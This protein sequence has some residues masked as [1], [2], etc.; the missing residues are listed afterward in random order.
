MKVIASLL[1]SAVAVAAFG[2]TDEPQPNM[3]M[4]KGP[5][6]G[7]MAQP[8]TMTAQQSSPEVK[9]G[10]GGSAICP[11]GSTWGNPGNYCLDGR[12][13]YYCSYP[14]APGQMSQNCGSNG[15][16]VAPPG[17]PDGCNRAPPPTYNPPTYSPPTPSP[18]PSMCY[19]RP[20]WYGGNACEQFGDYKGKDLAW[21]V[22]QNSP[23]NVRGGSGGTCQQWQN[24][25][26]FSSYDNYIYQC[27]P[28]MQGSS[29]A[30]QTRGYCNA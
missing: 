11:T 7:F 27:C 20:V 24:S 14:G 29:M 5:A 6:V 16:Y 9:G 26:C 30:Q 17:T 21:Q 19:S 4:A 18:K 22:C 1:A 25:Q 10:S 12:N 2:G 8:T 23:M 3:M 28:E 15:C 13:I